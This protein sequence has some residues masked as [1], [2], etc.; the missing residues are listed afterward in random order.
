MTMVGVTL[1]VL[2]CGDGAVKPASPPVPVATT[3]AVN[4]ASATLASFGETTRFTAEVRDQNG[5]VMS[6][7]AVAWTS[8][9][10]SVAAVDAS[11]QVTA[12]ANGSATITATTGT[13][14]GT[15]A[16]TVAQVVS[17][18]A[19][20]PATAILVA[21]GDTV[22]LVAE[23]SDANGH[24][25][26]A[27]VEFEW[28]SSD[29][30][31]ARVDASGLVESLA[32]GAAL[33]TATASDVTG[34]AE[35]TVVPPLP[36]AIAVSPDTIR[37][38][39]LGQTAQLVAEVREQAGRV[40]AEASVTW[41]SGDTL[42][43]AV[44]STGLVRAV[45]WGTTTVTAATGDVSGAVAVTVMQLSDREI[46]EIFYEVTGGPEWTRSDNWL[47]DAPLRGWYGVEVDGAGRVSSLALYRNN[48]TGSIPPELGDLANLANLYLSGN[49]LTGRIPPALGDLTNLY[50]LWLSENELTGPIPSRLG[51]LAN[52]Q[53][54]A[55]S[56]NGL[57]GLI[58]PELGN[59]A[60]LVWLYLG[61][62]ELTASLPPEIGGLTR[63]QILALQANPDMRGALPASLTNLGSLEILEASGTQLCARS[64]PSFLEWLDRL[65]SPRVVLCEGRPPASAYLVQAVQSRDFPVPLVAGEEAL[66]RVFVTAGRDNSESLPPVRASFHLNGALVHVADIP[67][68][69]G[70][71]PTEVD[72]S[73]LLKSA[74]AVIPPEVVRPG[75]EMVV[76]IDPDGTLDPALGVPQRIPASGR[77]TVDVSGMPVFDLTLV[78]FLWTQAPDSAILE[79]VAETG[80]DP[81]Y[82][83]WGRAPYLPVGELE[84]RAHEPVLSSSNNTSDLLV[85]TRV[86]RAMEGGTG[87]YMGTM[88]RPVT[89]TGGIA[90]VGGK[91]SFS[92]IP[93][94]TA[95]ELGHNFNLDHA[96]CGVRLGPIRPIRTR[97]QR[98]ESGGTIRATEAPSS[99]RPQRISCHTVVVGSA[100]ITTQ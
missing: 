54:L 79:S 89:G 70:P 43:V 33:V 55:L 58:P 59:L 81:E 98:S 31:V 84:V 24:S 80:A 83:L 32:E 97:A 34:G 100:T 20:S 56:A 3:V 75:L 71:I 40:M 14:S 18:V 36:T 21:F 23:A 65:A 15:A 78:P 72:E 66:L 26:D 7:A 12:A 49:G 99:H 6:G 68:G 74:N 10:A 25:V 63:L 60:N 38:T 1:V 45:G 41:S 87:Y 94:P 85:Q 90:F 95:H 46:L 57:T 8:S 16:V 42:V 47:T 39:A 50:Y 2:S 61:R 51:G 91:V 28:S 53:L 4:P 82:M 35:L 44:D 86:I 9:D 29:T 30:L 62:N 77:L 88:S 17:A 69:G 27:L 67:A 93:G 48:L 64:D 37:L 76:E 22:R 19:V 52:L 5:Q 73:S 96:P 92:L 11:G 13:V